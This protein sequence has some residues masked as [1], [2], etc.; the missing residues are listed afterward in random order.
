MTANSQ[1]SNGALSWTAA[2]GSPLGDPALR[3]VMQA[4]PGGLFVLTSA[5]DD[6][7][8]AALVRWLQPCSQ[9]PPLVMVA[10]RKGMAI[11]PLI[12]DSRCFAICQ[13]DESD[14]LLRRKFI[15]PHGFGE[16]PFITLPTTVAPSGAP[17]P[18][19]TRAYMDCSLQRRMDL[20]GDCSLYIGRIE[21]ATTL[22]DVPPAMVCDEEGW[23]TV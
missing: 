21:H 12:R 6:A 13:I 5:L 23:P 17:I 9:Q 15:T 22:H 2:K 11:E 14:R 4:I 20:E 3:A 7:R 10:L 18:A 19:G 16:D 1:P 8:G